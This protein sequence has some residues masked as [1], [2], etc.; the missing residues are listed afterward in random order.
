MANITSDF[1]QTDGWYQATVEVSGDFLM[2]VETD[3][4]TDLQVWQKCD[5]DAPSP[6][7]TDTFKGVTC[8]EVQYTTDF[9]SAVT[10]KSS[11][12]VTYASIIE[13]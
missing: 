7:L 12:P 8:K 10:I 3:K 4:P 2:H 9:A 6:D 5:P 11:E 13:A 1:Q